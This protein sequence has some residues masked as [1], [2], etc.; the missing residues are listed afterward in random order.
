[1][2]ERGMDNQQAHSSGNNTSWQSL[3]RAALHPGRGT[4]P[5]L[6]NITCPD[7]PSKWGP[8]HCFTKPS[9]TAFHG[10]NTSQQAHSSPCLTDF[11]Y[12][13]CIRC[14]FPQILSHWQAWDNLE[15]AWNAE[16]V[17]SKSANY[18]TWRKVNFLFLWH[19]ILTGWKLTW[20]SHRSFLCT[21]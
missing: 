14:R 17:E 2:C 21:S 12:L 10:E 1:M 4:Q 9:E 11:P 3:S 6:C 13:R 20:S 16:M 8:F 18:K 15:I 7:C 5:C 19:T